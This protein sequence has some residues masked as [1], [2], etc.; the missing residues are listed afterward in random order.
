MKE[1]EPNKIP[2][3]RSFPDPSYPSQPPCVYPSSKTVSATPPPNS[4]IISTFP[5]PQAETPTSLLNVRGRWWHGIAAIDN[6]QD[7]PQFFTS[8]HLNW[9]V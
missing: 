2:C 4:Q 3:R 5:P 9:G 6:A 7:Q 8:P 1:A